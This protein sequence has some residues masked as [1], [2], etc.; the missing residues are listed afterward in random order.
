MSQR[1]KLEVKA[2]NAIAGE[3]L[4]ILVSDRLA[5]PKA[6]EDWIGMGAHALIARAAAAERFKGKALSGLTLLAPD[7]AGYERLVLVGIG[8]ESERGKLD[9]AALGGAIAGRIGH[10]RSADIVA[11]LPDDELSAGEIAEIGLGLRLRSYSFDRYKTKKK[12]DEGSVAEAEGRRPCASADPLPRSRRRLRGVRQPSTNGV[13]RRARSRQRAAER[14][15]SPKSS[16]SAPRKLRQAR[17]SRSKSSTR[18][19]IEEARHAERCLASA[20]GSAPR[21]AASW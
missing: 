7:G 6:A 20:Q 8:P 13:E 4:V 5:P 16:P 12:D 18:R 15:L 21:E 14:A 3:D 19:R 2:L 9:F 11:A 17:R 10:G 1:L